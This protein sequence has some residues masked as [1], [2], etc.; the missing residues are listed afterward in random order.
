MASIS[1]KIWTWRHVNVLLQQLKMIIYI[2]SFFT[3]KKLFVPSFFDSNCSFEVTF[4][5]RN[6]NYEIIM[7]IPLSTRTLKIMFY[8]LQ[9]K[10]CR[11]MFQTHVFLFVFIAVIW[12][13]AIVFDF[14]V[15]VIGGDKVLDWKIRIKH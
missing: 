12:L 13:I 2:F 1:F 7:F 3:S 6:L 5:I 4:F 9:V 14:L 8:K 10:L 15:R 11:H